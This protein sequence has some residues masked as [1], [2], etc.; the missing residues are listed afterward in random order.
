MSQIGLQHVLDAVKVT[1]IEQRDWCD[2][3]DDNPARHPKEARRLARSRVGPLRLAYFIIEWALATP[4][5]QKQLQEYLAAKG[6]N[7]GSADE[8][9]DNVG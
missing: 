2:R 1:A 4:E 3:M 6:V 7:D 8:R 9:A 5:R